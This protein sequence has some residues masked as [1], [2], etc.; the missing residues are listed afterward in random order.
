MLGLG[1]AQAT[2]L[3]ASCLLLSRQVSHFHEPAA[4][5]N[6]MARDEAVTAGVVVT[7]AGT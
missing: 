2:H 1:K 3:A 5:L 7:L 6:S 4:G